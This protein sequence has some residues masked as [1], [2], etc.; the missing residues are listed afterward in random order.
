MLWIFLVALVFLLLAS[1]HHFSVV[2]LHCVEELD[3]GCNCVRFL[4]CVGVLAVVK[5]FIGTIA[6]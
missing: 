4:L 2:T 1:P 5:H 3:Y 6:R